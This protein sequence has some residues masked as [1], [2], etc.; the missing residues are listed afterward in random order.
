MCR[1]E[2]WEDRSSAVR[3]PVARGIDA[4]RSNLSDQTQVTHCL[5]S[6]D[7]AHGFLCRAIDGL[8][9]PTTHTAHENKLVLLNL[10]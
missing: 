8:P 2:Q 6:C 7:C 4:E 1:R 3:S 9:Q 5:S 10:D